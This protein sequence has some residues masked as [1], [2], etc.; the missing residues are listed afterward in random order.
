MDNGSYISYVN[1]W[2]GGTAERDSTGGYVSYMNWWYG[3]SHALTDQDTRIYW[4]YK[5][6]TVFHVGA[7]F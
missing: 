2:Y 6:T 1:W 5:A 7:G 3:G 4:G